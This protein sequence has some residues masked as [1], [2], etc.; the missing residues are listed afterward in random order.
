MTGIVKLIQIFLIVVT[1][2]FAV[3]AVL[4][5]YFR[6][7]RKPKAVSEDSRD[8][9]GFRR[10]DAMSY[11]RFDDICDDM[12]VMD[13][14]YSFVAAICTLS[15]DYYSFSSEG[16]LQIKSGF[17]RFVS[18]LA[19]P[20]TYH[21]SSRAIDL[22]PQIARY[23][24]QLEKV[25]GV[26]LQMS[27]D[28]EALKE[29]AKRL[30]EYNDT[31]GLMVLLDDMEKREARL[32]VEQRRC[33]HLENLIEKQK[34][35][36]EG[37][38]MSEREQVYFFSWTYERKSKDGELSL[39][40]IKEMAIRELRSMEKSY[41]SALAGAKVRATRCTTE[42]LEVIAKR[43]FHPYSGQFLQMSGYLDN[44]DYA[45]AVTAP[46]KDGLYADAVEEAYSRIRYEQYIAEQQNGKGEEQTLGG[47][48]GDGIEPGTLDSEGT[49]RSLF[50]VSSGKVGEET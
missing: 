42:Q 5:V 46:L 8:Y 49:A 25:R 38:Y 10:E 36:A 40:E 28:Y 15:P 30:K 26:V 1:A 13:G 45:F 47:M 31:G 20:I 41:I 9:S 33:K 16:R 21:Q 14:G 34:L 4:F 35:I 37:S 12:I 24:A 44:A 39:R 32:S 11:V 48:D 7:Y 23:E 2:G 3:G 17:M 27:V 19:N 22:A 43:H 29:E 18:S 50:E 6:K